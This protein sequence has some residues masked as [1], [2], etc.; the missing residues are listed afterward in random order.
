MAKRYGFNK[1]EKLKSRKQ[2]DAL[3]QKGAWLSAPPVRMAYRFMPLA[4][5]VPAYVQAGVTVSKRHFK[6]AVDRNRIKRLLREAYR[7]QKG[8][9]TATA[10]MAK[11]AV[12]VFFVYTDKALPSF[13]VIKGAVATGLKKLTKKL[14]YTSA[15]QQ[16]SDHL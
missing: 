3:F 12:Q 8:E 11:T 15:S 9:L 13:D 14:P 7:L 4:E 5:P 16:G 6:K 2:I 1:K 10:A